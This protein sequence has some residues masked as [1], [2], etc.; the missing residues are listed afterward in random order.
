MKKG[1]V[2]L[3]LPQVLYTG[4][5][6]AIEAL[7]GLLEGSIAYATDSNEQGSYNGSVWV[8]GS[9][10]GFSQSFLLMGG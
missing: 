6:A 4:T 5:K 1:D 3:G 9:V 8:W 2:Q 10:T 7:T